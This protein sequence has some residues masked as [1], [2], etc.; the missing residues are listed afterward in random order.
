M[1]FGF[2]AGRKHGRRNC[3][4]A[5]PHNPR[6]SRHRHGCGRDHCPLAHAACGKKLFVEKV[7]GDSAFQIKMLEQGVFPGS[8]IT[9]V[10]GSGNRPCLL[11]AGDNR[12]MIDS[13]SAEKIL[14]SQE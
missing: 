2:G 13:A 1:M 7:S 12:I 3:T 9:L 11:S 6:R 14:V 8:E 10:A 5:A 4:E